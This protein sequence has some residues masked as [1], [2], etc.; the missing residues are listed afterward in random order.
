MWWWSRRISRLPP[1]SEKDD[2]L[3]LAWAVRP[4]SRLACQITLTDD[5]S[6]LTVQC[7]AAPIISTASSLSSAAIC[8]L[9]AEGQS[10]IDC[11][12]GGLPR[13]PS[14]EPE[15]ALRAQAA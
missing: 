7:R 9:E 2:L 14:A 13:C 5:L 15:V 11:V 1:A 4:T 3:D 10:G 12:L 8:L 6:T